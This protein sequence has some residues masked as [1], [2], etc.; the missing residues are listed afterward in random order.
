MEVYIYCQQNISTADYNF[1]SIG[2]L[3]EN[4]DKVKALLKNSFLFSAVIE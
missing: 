1:G 3:R 2:R 4:M